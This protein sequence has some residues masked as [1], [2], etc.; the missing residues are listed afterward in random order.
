M[1]FFDNAL[2]IDI[3]FLPV[4]AGDLHLTLVRK[5]AKP[6]RANDGLADRVTFI[7]RNF[8]RPLYFHGTV[9][10][11]STAPFFAYTIDGE[12]DSRM[13]ILLFLQQTLHRRAELLGSS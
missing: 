3:E 8:L 11:N 13:I 7:R 4:F 2:E 6:A 12:N 5:I 9:N 1:S 10:I